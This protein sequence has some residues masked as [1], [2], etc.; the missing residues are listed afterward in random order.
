M[1]PDLII[2]GGGISKKAEKFVPYLS[3]RAPIV[4]AKLQNQAGI[5]GAAARARELLTPSGRRDRPRRP[6]TRASASDRT[7]AASAR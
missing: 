3:T 5:V 6:A 7:R 1:W 4:P 2:L